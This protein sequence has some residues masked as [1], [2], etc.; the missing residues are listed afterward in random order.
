MTI[1]D[2]AS[3]R[4]ALRVQAWVL[5]V[6]ALLGTLPFWLTDLDF[7]VAAHFYHPQADDPWFEGG[8][9]LWSFLYR[10]APVLMGLLVL[11]ALVALA[12]GSL[13]G[14]WRHL[15]LPTLVVLASALLG[16]GLLINGL[17]KEHWD[18]PRPH[19]VEDLGGTK[20]YLPP[21]LPGESSGGKSFPCG[22]SSVGYLL[23]VFYLVWR[24]RRPRLALGALVGALLLGTLLGVGRMAA[25]DHFLSDVIWSGIITYA[26][27]LALYL[28]LLRLL[29]REAVR[30]PQPL[31]VRASPKHRVLLG[32]G[33]GLFGLVTLTG[34]LLATPISDNARQVI[35]VEDYQPDPRV[36]RIEADQADLVLYG[37]GGPERGLVR[38]QARGFGLPSARVD[39]DYEMRDGVL[40]YRIAHQGVFTERDTRLALGLVAN[41]W[42]RIEIRV[43]S[44]DI[45]VHPL[46]PAGPV[47][48]LESADGVVVVE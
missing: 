5:G 34:V 3:E 11:G 6:I 48:D 47:L 23:G 17:L 19:Q 15:R 22:H 8:L 29:R 1:P 30:T 27:A 7:R 20:A 43:G 33:F 16:P 35:R 45:R 40:T 2:T 42:D 46:G 13:W 31:F 24:R 37:M 41:Q 26:V 44:G 10:G 12:A 38:F 36:L 28:G 9:P 21:L 39:Q 32:V 4:Q 25:G 18:R 14:R